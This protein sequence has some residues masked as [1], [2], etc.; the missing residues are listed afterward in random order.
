M[1]SKILIVDDDR[2]MLEVMEQA[3][4]PC[5]EVLRAVSGS[6]A[7][8]LLRTADAAGTALPDLILLDIE[9]PGMNGYE[10]LEQ[11]GRDDNILDLQVLILHHVDGFGRGIV[12][13]LLFRQ[14]FR[15]YRRSLRLVLLR[16]Y[17]AGSQGKA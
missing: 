1:N 17:G 3:L 9:M 14:D 16:T 15:R 5:Y 7:L 8:R 10:V 11:L 13:F 2:S 6:E 12:S 4:E